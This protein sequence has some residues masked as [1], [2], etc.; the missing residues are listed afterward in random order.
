MVHGPFIVP[1]I[2][3][4]M[5]LGLAETIPAISYLCVKQQEGLVVLGMNLSFHYQ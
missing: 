2:L 3:L 4:Q 1:D 5:C